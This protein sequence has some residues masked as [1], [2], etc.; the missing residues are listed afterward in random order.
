MFTKVHN[1]YRQAVSGKLV[2]I[3][4]LNN[5]FNTNINIVNYYTLKAKIVLFMSSYKLSGN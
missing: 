2:S 1:K 3:R 4:D 5:K